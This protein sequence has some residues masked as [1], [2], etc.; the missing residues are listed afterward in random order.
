MLRMQWA[1]TQ[2][3]E[4]YVD[5]Q[6]A[7]YGGTFLQ[8]E[9]F[10]PEIGFMKG[11]PGE[12][13]GYYTMQFWP[14]WR[15]GPLENK[16]GMLNFTANGD[17]VLSDY[18]TGTA[19]RPVFTTEKG[20]VYNIALFHDLAH[21]KVKL[22]IDGKFFDEIQFVKDIES[23]SIFSPTHYRFN[24]GNFSKGAEYFFNNYL[25]YPS[26]REPLCVLT[27]GFV[28]GGYEGDI[29]LEDE[30]LNPMLPDF[31]VAEN[32]H[33]VKVNIPAAHY[34]KEYVLEF[35]VNGIAKDGTL[36]KATKNGQG[37]NYDLDMVEIK[38]GKVYVLGVLV[39]E[40]TDIKLALA[41]DDNINALYVYVDGQKIAGTIYIDGDY[42]TSG[43]TIRSFTLLTECGDYEVSAL[44][45]YTGTKVK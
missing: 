25:H 22:Y 41:F 17:I 26:E 11:E 37:I 7:G 43:A 12:N 18:A 15:N 4:T 45:M 23:A 6:P 38:D 10:T 3:Y 1:G 39:S 9:S 31:D 19:G 34:L 24:F 20:K 14:G 5:V 40:T 2:G 13:G 35:A 32:G 30:L 21:N 16:W 28:G 44:K 8:A 33:D 27:E 29:T 36:L 42:A